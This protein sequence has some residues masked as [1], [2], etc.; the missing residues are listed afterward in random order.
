MGLELS[1]LDSARLH[2]PLLTLQLLHLV[3]VGLVY[4][5]PYRV[6]FARS[7][8]RYSDICHFWRRIAQNVGRQG[9]RIYSPHILLKS[10]RVRR[11][12]SSVVVLIVILS[13]SA[14][15]RLS[16]EGIGSSLIVSTVLGVLFY[17]FA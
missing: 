15:E 10:R 5:G 12:A 8:R 4:E 2:V 14:L 3:T 16:C 13:L 6:K 1:L 11:K 17:L 7:A 9:R